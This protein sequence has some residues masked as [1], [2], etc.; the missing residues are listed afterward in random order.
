MVSSSNR[1]AQYPRQQISL[2]FP[3]LFQKTPSKSRSYI[4]HAN[5]LTK[6]TNHFHSD[7]LAAHCPALQKTLEGQIILGQSQELE[8]VEQQGVNDS[9]ILFILIRPQE[10]S[11][12]GKVDVRGI[13]FVPA[14]SCVDVCLIKRWDENWMFTDQVDRYIP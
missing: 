1:S 9:R 5:I 2:S 3:R 14:E 10:R 12:D 8:P 4:I 11:E 6:R 13:Q 7:Q